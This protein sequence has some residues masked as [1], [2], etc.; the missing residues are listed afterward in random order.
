MEMV[1]SVPFVVLQMICVVSLGAM[2]N[3]ISFV[4]LLLL[5]QDGSGFLVVVPLLVGEV[6]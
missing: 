6:G 5:Q 2:N 4:V 3:D 1:S